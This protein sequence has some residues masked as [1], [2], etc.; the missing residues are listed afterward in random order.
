MRCD[1]LYQ[2]K[3][4]IKLL[5]RPSD[6]WQVLPWAGG[7]GRDGTQHLPQ[8]A[9]SGCL[10]PSSFFLTVRPLVEA[11]EGP[12]RMRMTSQRTHQHDGGFL[13]ETW[14][15]KLGSKPSKTA[16]PRAVACNS[17]S[18]CCWAVRDLLVGRLPFLPGHCFG[19][20]EEQHRH[21]GHSCCS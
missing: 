18:P 1:Q 9:R 16:S 10:H 12:V 11:K 21:R 3:I 5:Q 19:R 14:S 13:E 4:E 6:Q 17:P 15:H 8:A 20:A 2:S 7:K